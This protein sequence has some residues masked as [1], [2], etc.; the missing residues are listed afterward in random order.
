M[1][2]SSI[3]LRSDP[4]RVAARF[5]RIAG[6]Y[7][8]FEWLFMVPRHLRPLSVE[9]LHLTRGE[10]VISVGCGQ[11]ASLP[12]LSRAVGR[13]GQVIGVD[14]SSR[15]LERAY[16]RIQRFEINNV[17]IIQ[18]DILTYRAPAPYDAVLFSFSLSSFGDPHAVLFHMWEQLRPGGR[19]VVLDGQLPPFVHR[20]LLKPLL[21]LIRGFLETT[22]LG[23]PDMLMIDALHT[24]G[25]EVHVERSR[26]GTYFVA[27]LTKP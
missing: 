17:S 18:Q 6:V 9:R 8:F 27:S 14:L 21:P 7:P 25:A 10:R 19:L 1:P 23:D 2:T 16:E 13:N 24:L 5:D 20:W 11:G 12:L 3:P 22:V 15:M 26:W 4:K